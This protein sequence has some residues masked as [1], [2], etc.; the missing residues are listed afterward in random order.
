MLWGIVVLW[1]VLAGTGRADSSACQPVCRR[2]CP[3]AERVVPMQCTARATS[4]PRCSVRDDPACHGMDRTCALRASVEAV[5]GA[6]PMSDAPVVVATPPPECHEC[7]AECT[8]GESTVC[9]V[10]DLPD[11]STFLRP[12]CWLECDAPVNLDVG[13][14]DPIMAVLGADGALADASHGTAE[15]PL[16]AR[17][18][19]G[20]LAT[21]LVAAI[22]GCVWLWY[23]RRRAAYRAV[24]MDR[25]VHRLFEPAASATGG[26]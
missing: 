11:A 21:A 7:R 18:T 24:P 8:G 1:F 15:W 9:C 13:C 22:A 17:V 6:C 26:D 16:A 4:L 2:V 10:P 23:G 3:D 25:S 5:V 14:P 12:Y 19:A 20:A